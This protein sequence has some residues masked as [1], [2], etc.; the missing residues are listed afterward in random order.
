MLLK[1]ICDWA[2]E[3]PSWSQGPKAKILL[4]ILKKS[5]ICDWTD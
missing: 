1:K 5:E 3:V 4:E 2:D